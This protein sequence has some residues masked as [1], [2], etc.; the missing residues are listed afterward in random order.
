MNT[1]Q[2]AREWLAEYGDNGI[3]SEIITDLLAERD[4]LLVEIER[5]SKQ[6]YSMGMQTA[7]DIC[8]INAYESRI[9]RLEKTYVPEDV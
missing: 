3:P 7:Q 9:E 2:K 1:E 4:A 5:L 8:T 6:N